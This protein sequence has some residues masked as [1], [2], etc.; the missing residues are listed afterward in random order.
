VARETEVK[1]IEWIDGNV[2]IIDQARLPNRLVYVTLDEY[3]SVLKAITRL[4]VRGA[5]A[6]GIAAA[7]GM[8]L[9]MRAVHT[10]TY[11][12]FCRKFDRIKREFIAAR[13]TGANV[14]NALDRLEKIVNGNRHASVREI[15][16]MLLQEALRIYEEDR[17]TCRNIGRN[18]AELLK[19]GWAIVTHCNA[20]A[21]A[22]ADYGTALGCIYAAVE[23]GKRISVYVDET[24]PLLQG[25]RLTAW[26]LQRAGIDVTLICD[27]MAAWVMQTREVNCVLVGADRIAA[28]GDTANKIGTFGLAV[29]AKEHGIPFYVAA[30]TSTFDLSLEN[31]T[32]IPIEERDGTE[33]TRGF[34]RR[35]APKDVK[36]YNPAFD[37]TPASFITAIICESGIAI[38]PYKENLSRLVKTK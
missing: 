14:S 6:I 19:D 29:S 10:E 21:L 37:V 5:P 3:P 7:F 8:V 11:E 24:R 1:T 2:R 34:G 33:I 26:E 15:Q 17:T 35:T 36:V 4:Q 20:G 18:G 9:G 13:P 16:D 38:P 28:N 31:G 32:S 23:E 25:A 12:V 30:P 22:T 27:S